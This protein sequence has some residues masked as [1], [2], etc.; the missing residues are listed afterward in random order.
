M[1]LSC[2]SICQSRPQGQAPSRQDESVD[3]HQ[4]L[5]EG[6]VRSHSAGK[7]WGLGMGDRIFPTHACPPPSLRFIHICPCPGCPS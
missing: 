2:C 6:T 4:T 1:C 5:L 3:P 7:E